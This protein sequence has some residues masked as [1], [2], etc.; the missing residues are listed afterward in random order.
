MDV[1]R[2]FPYIEK[3]GSAAHLLSNILITVSDAISLQEDLNCIF[4][5]PVWI[6]FQLHM[7]QYGICGEQISLF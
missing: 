3:N 6:N 4:R 7:D 2:K 5:K 1:S